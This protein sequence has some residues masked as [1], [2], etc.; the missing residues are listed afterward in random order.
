MIAVR[1][2]PGSSTSNL[3]LSGTGD[4]N[5]RN[6]IPPIL[7]HDG[8]TS[9]DGSLPAQPVESRTGRLT[10]TYD[11]DWRSTV[12]DSYY[13]SSEKLQHFNVCRLGGCQL[14][15]TPNHRVRAIAGSYAAA[16]AVRENDSTAA[17]A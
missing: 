4:L 8:G 12:M 11:D 14:F 10:A 9:D 17:S 15:A 16:D 6:S 3:P 5:L 2:P 7:P 13:S 1:A